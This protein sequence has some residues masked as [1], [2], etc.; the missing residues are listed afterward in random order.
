MDA[1]LELVAG[2]D[3]VYINFALVHTRILKARVSA[4]KAATKVRW[5]GRIDMVGAEVGSR[6][7][8]RSGKSRAENAYLELKASLNAYESNK[9]C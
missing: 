1:K 8:P 4:S 3:D 5:G 6:T 2:E 9:S 7:E